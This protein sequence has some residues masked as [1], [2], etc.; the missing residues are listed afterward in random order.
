LIQGRR[1]LFMVNHISNT[2]MAK[3]QNIWTRDMDIRRKYF[4]GVRAELVEL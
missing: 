2:V 1:P 3:P 4:D